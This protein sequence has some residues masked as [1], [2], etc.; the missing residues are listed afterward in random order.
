MIG[1]P[2]FYERAEIKD[3]VAYLQVIDNPVDGVSLMRI[4][5]RPRRGIGDASLARL[6]AWADA[7]GESLFAALGHPEEAGLGPAQARAVTQLQTLLQ[8]LQSA[9]QELVR[10]RARRA[11]PRA[12]GLSRDPRGGADDRVSRPR[13]EP[14]GARR[15]HARVR[16]AGRG[17]VASGFLQE[18]SL[19]SDQDALR[20]QESLVTLMTIHNAKGLEFGA[21]FL[22]RDGGGD[23][24]ARALDR[25]AGDR[26]GAAPRLRRH[27]AC[28]G[29]LTL[30]HTATRTLYGTRAHNLPSRFLDELPQGEIVRERLRPFSW[31]AKSPA[32]RSRR[33]RTSRRSRPGT[34]CAT[35]RSARASSSHRARRH[36]R[37]A[38]PGRRRRAA[39]HARVR[40]AREDRDNLQRRGPEYRNPSEDELRATFGSRQRRLRQRVARRR[41]RAFR[42][43]SFRRTACRR[44]RRRQADRPPARSPSR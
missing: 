29:A 32:P 10:P 4:A 34:R 41:L 39:A 24:P 13:G 27:D 26:G 23:L 22:D 14:P 36:R 2:R 16:G 15:R 38:F 21:V 37:R 11:S 18:I 44:L 31:A 40:P 7:H 12:L 3:A 25:G 9:A 5:N 42:N 35:R 30:T 19:Y 17:A 8:S 20:D 43:G 28:E 33:V 1:G 6:Q